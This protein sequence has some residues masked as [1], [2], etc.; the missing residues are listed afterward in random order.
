MSE[1][2]TRDTWS[3]LLSD[4]QSSLARQDPIEIPNE[5]KFHQAFEEVCTQVHE[6]DPQR[7][8]AKFL[9]QHDQIIVFIGALDESIGFTE[10]HCLSSLFWSVAFTTVQ[11]SIFCAI[12]QPEFPS[13]TDWR[14]TIDRA[15]ATKENHNICGESAKAQRSPTCLRRPAATISRRSS[16]SRSSS[17][18]LSRIHRVL[19]SHA[20]ALFLTSY[21]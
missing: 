6:C 15:E 7:L 16:S 10:P 8:L 11:V 2:E 4:L 17:K 20:Y 18:S 5:N 1:R 12:S 21:S 3:T 9:R 13:R 19:L 14:I